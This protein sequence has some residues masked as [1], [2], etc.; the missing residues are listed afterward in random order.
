[1]PSI[2]HSLKDFLDRTPDGVHT[3][4]VSY[5]TTP[6]KGTV[7]SVDPRHIVVRTREGKDV[8]VPRNALA[9]KDQGFVDRWLKRH[10]VP[11]VVEKVPDISLSVLKQIVPERE[12][13]GAD[14]K[15]N[16]KLFF[17]VTL[18]NATD[19]EYGGIVLAYTLYKESYGNRN[20]EADTRGELQC[21]L[22]AK[23]EQT[24]RVEGSLRENDGRY[25]SYIHHMVV[26]A[27]ADDEIVAQAS[28]CPELLGRVNLQHANVATDTSTA[29]EHDQ[30]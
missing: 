12:A 30:P 6:I 10:P 1:M 19:R 23:E 22:S 26:Y 9:P 16:L 4:Y 18:R 29:S 2:L 17:D 25:D 3:F 27:I 28:D 24:H 20:W 7:A 15:R 21:T 14:G 11:K 13:G 5:R 8:V